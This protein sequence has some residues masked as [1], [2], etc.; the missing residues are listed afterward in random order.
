ME[1]LIKN[2]IKRMEDMQDKEGKKIFSSQR[3]SVKLDPEKHN[4][5]NCAKRKRNKN[6]CC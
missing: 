3:E 4:E 6:G 2:I 1:F 5:K